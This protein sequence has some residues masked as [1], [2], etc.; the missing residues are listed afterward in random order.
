MPGVPFNPTEP[1]MAAV[2][3]IVLARLKHDKDWAQLDMHGT[4]FD[5]YVAYQGN[6]L[7]GRAVLALHAQEAFWQLVVEGILVPGMNTHNPELPWFRITS[8][9]RV[10]LADQPGDPHD[11]AGYLIALRQRVV[12][13]DATALFYLG[14][15]LD[16]LRRGSAVASSLLLGIAAERVFVL[17]CESLVQALSSPTEQADL[18]S[19]LDRYPMRPKLDWVVKKM[20]ALQ[21]GRHVGLPDNSAT[22][23]SAIYDLLRVQR[24]ELGHPKDTPPPNVS[25]EKAYSN[26]QIFTAY[27]VC[28]EELRVFLTTTK[29]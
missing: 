2:R 23:M 7:N 3:Q 17:V 14:E 11:P 21:K 29:V 13:P 9:G 1:N 24:N 26:L 28:A 25:R 6:P 27:Y 20:E 16:T 10:V 5:R 8:Y 22:M 19:R 12:N 15:S 4:G 18:R